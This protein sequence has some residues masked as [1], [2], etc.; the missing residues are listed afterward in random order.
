MLQIIDIRDPQDFTKRVLDAP[1]DQTF[2]IDFW[3]PWCA[4]CKM[5]APILE[6]AVGPFAD[7]AVLVKVNVDENPDLSAHFGV[8]GIPA[9][10]IVRG[11][12]IVGEFAGA[13]PETV[14]R[15]IIAE[16]IPSETDD[17]VTRAEKLIEQ[18]K[19]KEAEA[20]LR[21]ALAAD[22]QHGE[23]AVAL[24]EL[25]TE[26][27]EYEAATQLA[28][29]VLRES[30]AY[31]AAQNLLAR[32]EFVRV[33]KAAGG[34]SAAAMCLTENEKDM[35]ARYRLGCCM[36]AD[37]D[38]DM[39]LDNFLECVRRARAGGGS[40]SASGGGSEGASNSGSGD[41]ESARKAMLVILDLLGRDDPLSE[42]YRA[43][44]SRILFS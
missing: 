8:Q 43:R 40:G 9:V 24:A 39:A 26:R 7:K 33:C 1:A 30:L 13:Q 25:L 3:A 20:L 14:V 35:G 28:Q 37:G 18:G 34:R 2:V 38:Y 44:L 36:A 11:G 23:A 19:E 22:P 17:N 42:T 12:E 27:G 5:L 16:A 6:A 29:G 41:G 31:A 32:T 15:K 21:K 4:P 10:K